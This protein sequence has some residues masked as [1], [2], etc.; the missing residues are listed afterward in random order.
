MMTPHE[1]EVALEQMKIVSSLF[2]MGAT[3]IGNHPFIEFTGLMNE[4]IKACH[5]AHAQGIDFSDCSAH[6]G[7]EL[8]LRRYNLD[9]LKEKL[10]CIFGERIQISNVAML[11]AD[12]PAPTPEPPDARDAAIDEVVAEAV[13]ILQAAADEHCG[14]GGSR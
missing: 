6:S 7:V 4:Y 1:R 9:Y 2:Y 11:M 10:E 5:Q 14:K 8:P 12:E 3:R 13:K